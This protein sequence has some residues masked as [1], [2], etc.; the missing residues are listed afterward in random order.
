MKSHARVVIVGG[1]VMGVGLLYHLALEGW[2]DIALVEKGELTSGSTWHA[3]G[4]VG[5]LRSS[6]NITRLLGYSVDLYDKLEAE[7]G[8]A[9]GWV[10]NGSLRLARTKDRRAEFERAYT[11]ARSFGL[12]FHMLTPA[13]AKETV[14][15]LDVKGLDCAAFVPSDGVANPS[16]ITMAL[17][18]GARQGGVRIIEDVVVTAIDTENGTVKGVQTNRGH[19]AC[20]ILVNCGGIWAPEIGRMAGVNVPLQPSHHQY[21]VTEKIEGLARH[22]PA[23]RDTDYQTY[24]K[25]DVGGLQ[26]GGYEFNPIP[27]D[28]PKIPD[29]HEFRLM[30]PNVDHF[31]PLLE[32]AMELIPALKT[33]GVK[34]WFNGIEALERAL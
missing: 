12:E 21:F 3:A 4:A 5:Q 15:Q 8:Q 30:Q 32:R 11:T 26:V 18:K 25:E 10:R 19:I 31:E 16:D 2:T 27:F 23:I 6:A 17:A 13:Q 29:G 33:V 9:T 20:D 14:P 22:I 24:F 1:G 7:T 28:V 34:T